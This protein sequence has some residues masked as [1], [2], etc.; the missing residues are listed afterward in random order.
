MADISDDEAIEKP[1]RQMSAAQKEALKKGRE[2]AKAN[3]EAQKKTTEKPVEKPTEKVVEKVTQNNTFRIQ[4]LV[5][6]AA[7][8]YV[9]FNFY[10]YRF[11][12]IA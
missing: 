11:I 6:T 10:D 4:K 3:R 9:F 2:L 8:Y 1:K 7:I 12:I 5:V